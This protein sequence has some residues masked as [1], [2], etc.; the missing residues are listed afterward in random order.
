VI[1]LNWC[2]TVDHGEVTKIATSWKPVCSFC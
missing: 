1:T 2:I